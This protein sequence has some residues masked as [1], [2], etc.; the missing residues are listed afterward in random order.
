MDA[1]Q[2]RTATLAETDDA[3]FNNGAVHALVL[4]EN[5]APATVSIM[6]SPS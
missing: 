2:K 3:R 5:K 6:A 4:I 1:R